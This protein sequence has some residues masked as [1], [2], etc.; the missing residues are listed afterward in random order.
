MSD[1]KDIGG[2]AVRQATAEVDAA[3]RAAD[4]TAGEKSKKSSPKTK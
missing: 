4:A 1:K 2:E 3:T